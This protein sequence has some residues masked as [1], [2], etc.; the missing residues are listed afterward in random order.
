MAA[1]NFTEYMKKL[2]QQTP[3]Q[4]YTMMENSE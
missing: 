2:G 1:K 4:N 3:Q